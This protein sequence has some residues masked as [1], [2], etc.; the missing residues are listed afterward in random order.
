[1]FPRS[2][3]NIRYRLAQSLFESKQVN[4]LRAIF[5]LWQAVEI[6]EREKCLVSISDE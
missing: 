6:L 5:G 3:L 4:N 1:M 2:I